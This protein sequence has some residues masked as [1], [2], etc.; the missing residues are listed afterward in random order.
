MLPIETDQL[1][2]EQ[3]KTWIN[4]VVIGCNFC[5]FASKVMKQGSVHFE[6]VRKDDMKELTERLAEEL[7]RLDKD[8]GI[9]TTLLILPELFPSFYDYLDMITI[10]EHFLKKRR[11]EGIYQIAS[12]HPLYLFADAQAD[13]PANYTNRSPYPMIHLLREAS[14][15]NAL[16]N[17]P[18]PD[19]I[20]ERNI[21][22]A[23]KKGLAYMQ[24][25]RNACF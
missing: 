5:P 21:D 17:F 18:D 10:C 13:D 15:T 9:E 22:F 25:L 3:T 1:V 8:S 4:K 7:D 2:I 12:F 24:V 19:N 11:K 16:K 6:V 14:I 23:R 20:P